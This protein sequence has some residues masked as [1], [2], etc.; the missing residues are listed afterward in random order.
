LT[1]TGAAAVVTVTDL[2]GR[3]VIRRSMDNFTG[4]ETLNI[5]DLKS[6]LYLVEVAAGEVKMSQKLQVVK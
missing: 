6:G 5:A 3:V 2:Q 1:S 4:V